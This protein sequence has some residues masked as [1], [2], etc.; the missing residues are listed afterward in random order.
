MKDRLKDPASANFEDVHTYPGAS[1]DDRWV[2]GSVNAKNG[3]GDYTG[4]KPFV[5]HVTVADRNPPDSGLSARTATYFEQT[6]FGNE[7]QEHC[8]N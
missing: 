4:F 3:F 2:C 5:A 6:M 1:A 8:R 7:W